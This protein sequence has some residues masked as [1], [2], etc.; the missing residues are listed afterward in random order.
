[1]PTLLKPVAFRRRDGTVATYSAGVDPG[2]ADGAYIQN[3]AAWPDGVIPYAALPPENQI[4]DG[5]ITAEDIEPNFLALIEGG[6]SGGASSVDQ[7][8]DVDL[9]GRQ[10][11]DLLGWSEDQLK[12]VP[13]G[14]NSGTGLVQSDLYEADSILKADADNTPSPLIVP[15]SRL[16]GRKATGGIAALTGPEAQDLLGASIKDRA[17]L[18]STAAHA[19]DDEFNDGVL[20]PAWVRYDTNGNVTVL[21]G[22]D[23]V[24]MNHNGVGGDNA[25]PAHCLLRPI[26]ALTFPLTIESAIRSMR[27]ASTNYHM[28]GL[29]MTDGVLATSKAVWINA[30]SATDSW[31]AYHCRINTFNALN[32]AEI[33]SVGNLKLDFP[34][35]SLYQRLKWSAVNTFQQHSG[36]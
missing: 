31:G 35:G 12:F 33:G 18:R 30:F 19:L 14:F 9:T 22:A 6:G 4:T 15:P 20:N 11:Q 1:M 32:A 5:S 34:G 3:P 7:L 24:N 23:V 36:R 2:A 29:I 8:T 10:D 28:V 13:T 26:G 17:W 25:G 16:I 21:E 27:R